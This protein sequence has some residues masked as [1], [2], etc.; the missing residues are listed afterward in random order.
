MNYVQ[1]C[2]VDKYLSSYEDLVNYTKI[3]ISFLISS[4]NEFGVVRKEFPNFRNIHEF[5][6][7]GV[8]VF[9]SSSN[10]TYFQKKIDLKKLFQIDR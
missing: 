4:M 7:V 5:I 3:P 6:T 9:M 2:A 1:F 10:S 8:L